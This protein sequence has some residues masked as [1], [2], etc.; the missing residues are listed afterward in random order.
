M[1]VADFRAAMG[2]PQQLFRHAANENEAM[3]V[4]ELSEFVADLASEEISAERIETVGD[5][6]RRP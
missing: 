3:S 2:W 5:E 1:H 4:S 6:S